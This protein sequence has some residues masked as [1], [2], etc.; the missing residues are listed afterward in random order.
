MMPL[1]MVMPVCGVTNREPKVDSSVCVTAAMLPSRSTTEKCV[2]QAGAR[3][4]GAERA[5]AVGVAHA[6][7]AFAIGRLQRQRIGGVGRRIRSAARGLQILLQEAQR[8]RQGRPGGQFRRREHLA[9]AIGDRERLARDG[10]GRRRGRRP[11]ARRQPSLISAAM[12]RARSP[13]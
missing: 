6:L 9:A 2:V 3:G 8:M 1:F 12:L 5:A 4:F 10:R 7:Q 13:W 11:T